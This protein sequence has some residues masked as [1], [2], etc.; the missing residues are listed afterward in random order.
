MKPLA[1]DPRL[2]RQRNDKTKKKAFKHAQRRANEPL[3]VN[4][5]PPQKTAVPSIELFQKEDCP[6][7][8]SVRNRL[9]HMGLDFIAHTVPEGAPLKHELLT[10]AGGKDQIPFLVDHRTGMKLYETASIIQ[11]LDKEYGT[12]APTRLA[13]LTRNLSL[14]IQTRSDQLAW[15]IRLPFEHARDVV[16][17]MTMSLKALRESYQ[18]VREAIVKPVPTESPQQRRAA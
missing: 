12:P 16:D 1:S 13:L 8:H 11:Y 6:F 9:S 15:A 3:G 5:S 10:Q 14:R 2:I 4:S 17:D 7:S 18:S